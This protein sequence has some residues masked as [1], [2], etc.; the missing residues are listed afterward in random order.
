M[1][2][3][4]QEV[5]SFEEGIPKEAVPF[6]SGVVEYKNIL[7]EHPFGALASYALS[8]LTTPISN[9][10]VERIVSFVTSVKTKPRNT[11]STKLLAAIVGIRSHLYFGERCSKD[12]IVTPRV[13]SLFSMPRMYKRNET[14][15]DHGIEDLF[16]I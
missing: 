2:I 3:N 10:L 12:F 5:P 8:C 11:I 6:W 14:V 4:W 1:H 13:L 7:G 16:D 9:A 15:I